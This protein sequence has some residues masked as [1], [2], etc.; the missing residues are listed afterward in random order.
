MPRRTRPS[1]E[2]IICATMANDSRRIL[3]TVRWQHVRREPRQMVRDCRILPT[4]CRQLRSAAC[5]ALSR[6]AYRA[7]W[8]C[9]RVAEGT[10]LLKRHTFYRV[11][12]VRIPPAPPIIFLIRRYVVAAAVADRY[13]VAPSGG[14]IAPSAAH[15]TWMRSRF[16]R[17]KTALPSPANKRA[18]IPTAS[19]RRHMAD[20]RIRRA[21]AAHK[22]AAPHER[23]LT[24]GD[25][26]PPHAH[27][28]GK[29]AGASF[30]EKSSS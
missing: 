27:H 13:I 15:L 28:T 21:A 23:A 6:R 4:E 5:G 25:A 16:R 24:V 2:A 18:A 17:G 3:Q 7:G 14:R 29:T 10:A 30:E 26:G 1:N 9:G 22:R 19:Q 8:S 20:A 12:R 11:S